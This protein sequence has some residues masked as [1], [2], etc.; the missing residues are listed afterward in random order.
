MRAHNTGRSI[1]VLNGL[2]VRAAQSIGLHRDGQSLSLPI[3]ET[4]LRRRL[5]W[6]I[7]SGDTRAAE[8]HGITVSTS[9]PSANIQPPS[10]VDDADLYP[11]MTSLPASS[12]QSRWTE[13]S[14]PLIM[15]EHC[16]TRQQ[17]YQMLPP[18]QATMPSESARR[19][20][21]EKSKAHCEKAYFQYCNPVIPSQRAA[22]LIGRAV[23]GKLDFVSRL[24]W[25]SMA[26][27]NTT[28]GLQTDEETFAEACQILEYGNSIRSDELLR[29]YRWIVDMY[30][31]YHMLLFLLWRLCLEPTGPS[32]ERAWRA[33]DASFEPEFARQGFDTAPPGSKWTVLKMLREKARGVREK[34][35]LVEEAGGMQSTGELPDGGLEDDGLQWDL[36]AELPDWNELVEDLMTDGF[37]IRL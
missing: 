31:S 30:P 32:V 13:M 5:W 29:N 21:L 1:W 3:L 9:C 16:E 34:F 22:M 7:I 35:G 10:N 15:K 36:D 8:D 4:E 20:I 27:Q 12:R 24:Q 37:E 33:V 26:N 25:R 17:L 11:G 18:L 28:R 2:V 6:C 23:I 19:E 14:L